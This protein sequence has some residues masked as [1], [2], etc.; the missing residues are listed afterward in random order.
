MSNTAPIP[1]TQR[2]LRIADLRSRKHFTPRPL[3][4]EPCE[5]SEADRADHER[6]VERENWK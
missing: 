5:P 2:T 1:S 4:D 3:D 6:D